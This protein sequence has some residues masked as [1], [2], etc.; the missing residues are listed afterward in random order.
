MHLLVL[1]HE[2]E[3]LRVQGFTDIIITVS[4]LGQQIVNKVAKAPLDL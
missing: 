1:E 4:H 3:C 2:L